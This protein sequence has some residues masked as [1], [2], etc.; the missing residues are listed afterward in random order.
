[1][2]LKQ[3]TLHALVIMM[4]TLVGLPADAA[5]GRVLWA[6]GNVS[7]ERPL[8]ST[9]HRGDRL[10]EGDVIV[11]GPRARAQLLLADDQA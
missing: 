10:E 4:A 3:L 6:F 1:M 11:T 2:K 7:V 8:I 5:V 9:L